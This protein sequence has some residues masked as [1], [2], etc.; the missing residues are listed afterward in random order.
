MSKLKNIGGIVYKYV[1]EIREC[2]KHGRQLHLGAC[3]G[4]CQKCQTEG[5]IKQGLVKP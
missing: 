4:R 5:L 1:D 2:P 3:G